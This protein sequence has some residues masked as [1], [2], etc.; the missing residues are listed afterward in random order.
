MSPRI[1]FTGG[2]SAGHVTPNLAL[3]EALEQDSWQIAY[4]GSKAGIEKGMVAAL[5]I[6]YY[7]V[8]SG[9]LR[10]YFSWQNFLDPFKAL[11][12]IGQAYR[13]LRK[14]KT[15]VVFSKGGFVAFPVVVAAWFN[16]IPVIAHESDMSPGL[17]N[18]LSFPFVNKICVN[19]AAAKQHFKKQDKIEITGTPIRQELFRGS[20]Q[21]GL[22]LCGFK[23]AK[24]CLLVMGGSQGSSGLNN[25]VRTT[26][27]ALCEH[28]QII[29]LCGKGKVDPAL[30]NQADYRQF[31]YANRE[32][33]DLFA[34]SDLVVS[35]AGAN[36]IAE[37]LAL[38]KPHLLIPLS[39]KVSRGDQIQN[40]SYFQRLG[41]SWVIDEEA[42]TTERFLQAI[43]EVSD[44]RDK[45]INKIKALNFESATLRIIA[46]IKEQAC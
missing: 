19:F 7:A 3:I 17:A 12:G 32:L 45:I 38:E 29:H 22:A 8:S 16:R 23:E 27:P 35:R 20:K 5:N 37:I 40:A 30:V 10:R 42:L 11:L 24:P 13:L 28:Y 34:A 25:T 41:I 43:K 6:P 36:A 44:C 4:I 33:A 1:V 46:L 26:L 15:E 14:L 39:M 9:K 21:A 18:R 2:G 31:E